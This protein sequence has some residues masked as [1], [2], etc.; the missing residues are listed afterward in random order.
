MQDCGRSES[1]AGDVSAEGFSATRLPANGSR[2]GGLAPGGSENTRASVGAKA[3][4]ELGRWAPHLETN[5]GTEQG[6]LSLR[7]WADDSEGGRVECF[8]RKY[9]HR[10]VQ[11]TWET[12]CR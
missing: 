7:Q 10:V 5:S 12:L 6:G 8:K 4:S 2:E 1:L 11:N 9:S 3:A